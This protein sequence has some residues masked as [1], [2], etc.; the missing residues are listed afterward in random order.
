MIV[1][2]R[3]Q[4]FVMV[5][6]HDHANVSGEVAEYWNEEDFPGLHRKNEVVLAVRQHDRGWI[7]LDASPLW[8]SHDRKPYSFMD[9][10]LEPKIS[11]YKKG[12]DEVVEISGYAGLLCSLHY[13]SFLEN[14]T[15]PAGKQYWKEEIQRQQMLLKELE[16][17]ENT[18]Q[19]KEL[20][21]HLDL[22]KF[23]DN[24]SLYICLN[25]PGVDKANE[26]PFYRNGFPQKFAFAQFHRIIPEWTNQETIK[27]STFPLTTDL[28]VSL[29]F[30]AVQKEEIMKHG[31]TQAYQ[32]AKVETRRVKFV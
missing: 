19:K 8:N 23:C 28:H 32:E 21:E 6:Q 30:K 31:L 29:P 22:L 3:E 20:N 4:D 27:L 26:H 25:K 5:T 14:S 1:F 13:A 15:D 11:S 18:I 7:N 24:I 16:I 9:Y 12:I 10:P 17:E 2:E